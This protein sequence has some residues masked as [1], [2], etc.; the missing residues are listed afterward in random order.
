MRGYINSQANSFGMQ[1]IERLIRFSGCAVSRQQVGATAK[2][3]RQ[4]VFCSPIFSSSIMR[5][6][7]TNFCTLPVT[8]MGISSTKRMYF[9]IL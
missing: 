3:R 8:V 6:R 2:H 1:N 5:E 9:G 4:A 7:I